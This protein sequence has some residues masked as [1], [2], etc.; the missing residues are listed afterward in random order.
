M[1]LSSLFNLF[2]FIFFYQL[3]IP[4]KYDFFIL[5]YF[6]NNLLI[7][8]LLSSLTTIFIFAPYWINFLA[9]STLVL[10]QKVISIYIFY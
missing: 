3:N 6:Y 8:V 2:I 7:M 9:L 4:L 10:S 1:K 5:E